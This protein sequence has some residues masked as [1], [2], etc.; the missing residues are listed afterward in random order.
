LADYQYQHPELAAELELVW[1]GNLPRQWSE[2]IPEF[3]PDKP[4][5]TRSASGKILNAI[6]GQ[7]PWL[8]GGSADLA[9]S[10]NTLIDGAKD[11]NHGDFSGRNLHFGVREHSMGA[12]SNGLALAGIRPY[13]GTFFV[14]TDYMRPSI[15]LSSIMR[16][17]V[18][19]IMTHDSIGLGEDGPTHQPVEHLA[20]C[21]AIP[22]VT[23]FRPCDANEVAAGYRM[24]LTTRRPT[25]LVLTR[26]NV[27]TLD[28]QRFSS[29]NLAERGAYILWDS[30]KAPQLILIGTGSEL[31]LCIDAAEQLVRDRIRVRVVSMPSWELFELQD[32]SYREQVL[33]TAVTARVA[34][35]AGIRQGWDRYIGTGG[36]F[37]GMKSFGA[38]APFEKLYEHFNITSKAIVSAAKAQ[39]SIA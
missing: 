13:A 14:F 7:L 23:V 16:L 12:I 31:A 8:I 9:P 22:G 3:S 28:R 32:P 35:E 10:N 33:P 11:I 30:D 20:A 34:V 25:I 37:V 27:P 5:A 26:Q 39:L 36:A 6:A 24:A 21:R 29:A 2:R 17:P 4:I 15:R 38:S 19:Y 1:Q 18:I